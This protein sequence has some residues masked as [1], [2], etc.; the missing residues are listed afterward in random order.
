[1]KSGSFFVSDHI[2]CI[3]LLLKITKTLKLQEFF[4]LALNSLTFHGQVFTVTH[5]TYFASCCSVSSYL[6]VTY[7]AVF[8]IDVITYTGVLISP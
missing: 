7:I 1:L 4:K 2:D 5:T 3:R 8:Q 6:T